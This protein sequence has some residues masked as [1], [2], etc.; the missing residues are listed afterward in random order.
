MAENLSEQLIHYAQDHLGFTR[1]GII[2]ATASQTFPQFSDWLDHHYQADMQWLETEGRKDKRA[3]VRS[4]LPSGQSVITLAYTYRTEDLPLEIRNDPSR[5]IFARYT[6]GRDYHHVI[7]KRLLALVTYLEEQ[8]GDVVEARA[9]VDT[10]PILERELAERAGIGFVGNNSMLISPMFGSYLFLSEII[11]NVAL[12]PVTY[13]KVGGCRTCRKC[14]KRC[15]TK[16]IVDNKVIDARKC[17]SYLTIESKGS[18]PEELRPLLKNRIYGCDICQEVCPWN[19]T[20]KAKRTQNDWLQAALDRQAPPLLELASL[21]EEGFLQ[22]FQGTPIMR[23]KRVGL[24]RNVA[25]ALGNWGSAEAV[26]ALEQL[27]QDPSEL[28]REHALWGLQHI[29]K[30]SAI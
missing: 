2:P 7:K 11:V 18:I 24:L 12:E 20:P 1:V 28:I 13:K 14:V 19:G 23:A 30:L 8:L 26:M 25:V 10:G 15:P 21:T 17:I 16:A 29:D 5:G 3:D 27:A 4:V 6:W 9:Y 22:R